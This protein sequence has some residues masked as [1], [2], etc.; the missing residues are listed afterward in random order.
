MHSKTIPP[1]TPGAVVFFGSGETSPS[2]QRIFDR[3]FRRLPQSPR[4]A[5]L[6]TPAGF[7]LNSPQVAGRVRDFLRHHLQNYDPKLAIVP[8]RKR[9]TPFSPNAPLVVAPLLDSDLVFMGPGSP[10]Y[11]VRQLRD[12]LAWHF[13]VAR[14]RLGTCLA[15]AS[16]ATIAFGAYALPVYEIYKVGEELHWKEG[17]DFFRPF[18]LSLVFVPHWNNTDGGEELD[19]SRCYM[20]VARFEPLLDMLP[21]EAVVVGIDEQTGLLVDLAAGICQVVGNEGVTL[22]RD[23]QEQR[24]TSEQ[25]FSLADL[26]PFHL[27]DPAEGL[28][29]EVWQEV[30]EAH[31]QAEEVPQPPSRA[32]ALLAARDEA[33]ASK[34]WQAAD[35]LR[36]QI[37]SLGWQVIDT[38]SGSRLERY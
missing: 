37:E 19:T 4:V 15:L 2:G 30:L 7:E 34:D 28:P 10:T 27:P 24:F 26:G 3:I 5:L 6:E 21:N 23:G 38:P 1:A 18:G 35:S 33:R 36:R 11:V 20:G 29:A 25:A 14:H 17:L 8:A 13:L 9:G 22:I 12:S 16:A 31:R 32:L